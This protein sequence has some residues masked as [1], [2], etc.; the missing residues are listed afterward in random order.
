MTDTATETP[1]L[2]DA[3]H[4]GRV[5]LRVGSLDRV[6]PF[7]RDVVG[8]A[9]ER[10]GSR[11]VL[12][13]GNTPLV[14]LNEAPD[15]PPRAGDQAGL[16]HLAIRVPDRGALGDVLDRIRDGATLSGASDHLVSEALYLRDP[17]GNGVEI[18]RDRPR[19]EW[20][21][22][23]D[24]RVKMDTLPLD[25]D[26]VLADAHG[27]DR[28]PVGTDLGHVHLEVTDLGRALDFYVDA[29]GM[30]LRDDGYPNAAFVAAGGY[31]H[32]VGLNRW[33]DRRAPAGE[34]HGIQWFE[35]VVPDAETLTAVRDSLE[36][37]G[38]AVEGD[39]DSL[40]VS[41]PDGIGVR[42]ALEP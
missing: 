14:V 41:D 30:N 39:G 5:A 17:E 37:H 23:D 2:T 18:Y 11:A 31:H 8:L 10:Y 29:L 32:H 7:Y 25:L 1:A 15:A 42:V 26:S 38:Y 22:K 19:E 9:V 35:V 6:V 21:T 16:F 33:N 28:A 20:P 4:P 13:A 27:D 24:G 3:T 40:S 12:S 36:E 34:S